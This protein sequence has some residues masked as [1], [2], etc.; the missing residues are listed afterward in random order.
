MTARRIS[1]TFPARWPKPEQAPVGRE[2]AERSSGG[3]ANRTHNTED[4]GTAHRSLAAYQFEVFKER[5][6][7]DGSS[8]QWDLS[9]TLAEATPAW[10]R[11]AGFNRR[12]MGVI[13]EM[14]A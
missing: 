7:C 13:K 8:E 3:I 12:N 2:Q 1:G 11:D 6:A 4:A 9:G 14:R 10:S 5:S